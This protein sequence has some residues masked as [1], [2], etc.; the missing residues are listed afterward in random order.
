LQLGSA[1]LKA[2]PFP[3]DEEAVSTP[4]VRPRGEPSGIQPAPV[5]VPPPE[6]AFGNAQTVPMISQSVVAQAVAMGP[7]PA[8][9]AP[10]I[11]PPPP[12]VVPP[13][14]PSAVGLPPPSAVGLPPPS[15]VA[16]PPPSAM[17]PFDP[18]S[19]GGVGGTLPMLQHIV[20]VVP[21]GVMP[22]ATQPVY[23]LAPRS[24]PA[25]G[26]EGISGARGLLIGFL[27]GALLM[28]VVAIVYAFVVRH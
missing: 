20:P 12:S 10:A 8:A 27:A 3:P 7:R 6:P 21:Q 1:Q 23:P 15:A 4:P 5:V 28:G 26:T 25:Q 18:L 24:A 17:A 14:P 19:R 13:A 9:G 22:T 16:P 2:K 11:P